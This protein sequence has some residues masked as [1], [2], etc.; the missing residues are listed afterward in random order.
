MIF[1]VIQFQ[2]ILTILWQNSSAGKHLWPNE[3]LMIELSFF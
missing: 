2:K 1:G 3:H